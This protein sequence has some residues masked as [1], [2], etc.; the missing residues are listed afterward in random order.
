MKFI[1]NEKI[2]VS[3]NLQFSNLQHGSNNVSINYSDD[4]RFNYDTSWVVYVYAIKNR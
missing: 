1:S 2:K 3:K 4:I